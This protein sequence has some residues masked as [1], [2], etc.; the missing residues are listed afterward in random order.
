LAGGTAVSLNHSLGLDVAVDQLGVDGVGE[1]VVDEGI[2]ARQ[3]LEV[4]NLSFLR[5]H[6]ALGQVEHGRI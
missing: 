5:R 6:L 2:T 1:E 3:V 4:L